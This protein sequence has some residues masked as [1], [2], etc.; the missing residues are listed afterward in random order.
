M[1]PKQKSSKSARK[2]QKRRQSISPLFTQVSDNTE[3]TGLGSSTGVPTELETANFENPYKRFHSTVPEYFVFDNISNMSYPQGFT[4][5]VLSPQGQFGPQFAQSAPIQMQSL[6]TPP[7][8]AV[9]L[10][11]DVKSIKQKVER[12]ESVEKAVNNITVKLNQLE[13]KVDS[14]DKRVIDVEKN[15]AFINEKYE[16]HSTELKSAQKEI[17][18]L[19]QSC[20]TLKEN[21]TF[22]ETDRD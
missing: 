1:P 15:C 21:V 5:Q 12:I 10:M 18:Q 19:H 17:K 22:I 9:S 11:D 20:N 16:N 4:T 7:P 3:K 13:T 2:R 6:T 8:W 14:I